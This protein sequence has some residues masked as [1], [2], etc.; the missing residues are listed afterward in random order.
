VTALAPKGVTVVEI[1]GQTV[2]INQFATQRILV[3][4]A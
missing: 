4:A 2:E 3:T 1:D